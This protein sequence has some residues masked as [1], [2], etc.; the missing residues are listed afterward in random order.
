MIIDSHTHIGKL[1]HSLYSESYQ[2][3]LEL[4]LKEAG[5]NKVDKLIIIAGLEKVDGF[6]ISTL[7][8]MSQV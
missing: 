7:R 8:F 6:N 3:N 1:P 2:K 5:E 4:I